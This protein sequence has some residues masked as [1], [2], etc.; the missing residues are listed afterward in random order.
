V[1]GAVHFFAC[2]HSPGAYESIKRTFGVVQLLVLAWLGGRSWRFH[3]WEIL[4]TLLCAL[5]GVSGVVVSVMKRFCD[6]DC[7][8]GMI[9]EANIMILGLRGGQGGLWN[10]CGS[11]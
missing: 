4:T 10:G 7:V 3:F 11:C 8:W 6:V 1:I 5:L 2:L 9:L